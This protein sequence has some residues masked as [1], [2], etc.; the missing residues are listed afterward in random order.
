MRSEQQMNM[1]FNNWLEEGSAEQ[2]LNT[3][4]IYNLRWMRSE[5]QVN[6]PSN[7]WLE[8]GSEQ[9]MNTLPI[10]NH[11]WKVQQNSH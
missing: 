9:Q 3:R 10:Y 5:Q 1:P 6:M 4:P 2:P 7:N 8:E 11:R